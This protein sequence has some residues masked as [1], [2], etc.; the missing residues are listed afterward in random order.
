MNTV[1][2]PLC[3][4]D[5]LY[6]VS[7]T[8]VCISVS[9]DDPNQI[10]STVSSVIQK[11]VGFYLKIHENSLVHV[12]SDPI[13]HQVPEEIQ[14]LDEANVWLKNELFP[15]FSQRLASIAKRRDM[16]SLCVAHNCADGV[17]MSQ[18]FAALGDHNSKFCNPFPT[19]VYEVFAEKL[20]N[21]EECISPSTHDP[22]VTRFISKTMNACDSS[23]EI[24][25]MI[26]LTDLQSFNFEKNGL[27]KNT[28]HIW[29]ALILAASLFNENLELKG[30]STA[31]NMRRML[32]TKND[33]NIGNCV[34]SLVPYPSNVNE[35]NTLIEITD[36]MRQNFESQISNG[37]VFGHATLLKKLFSGGDLNLSAPPPGLSIEMSSIGIFKNSGIFNDVRFLVTSKNFKIKGATSFISYTVLTDKH[38]EFHGQFF[39]DSERLTPIEANQIVKYI[40]I[41]LTKVPLETRFIDA[42][43]IIRSI[44]I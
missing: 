3:Y 11:V 2:R 37:T 21:H 10:D 34:A 44:N 29:A 24:S 19:S 8:I 5:Q 31:I 1:S 16:I 28:E 30:I 7:P 18:L 35:T 32:E 9:I 43:Q 33:W 20:E 36:S 25:F 17:F 40:Q 26:P 38:K 41:A 15:D 13:I 22:N 23:S 27:V 14:S 4:F 6:N 39:Y 42:L 12:E